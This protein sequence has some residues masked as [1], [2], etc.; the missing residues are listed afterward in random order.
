MTPNAIP[1]LLLLASLVG[2]AWALKWARDR[3]PGLGAGKGGPSLR[4]LSSLAL[5]PQQRVVTVEIG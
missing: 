5:G 4:V 1:A 3:A 2:I